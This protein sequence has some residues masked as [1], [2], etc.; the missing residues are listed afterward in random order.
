MK[1]KAISSFFVLF[2]IAAGIVAM[3]PVAFAD[4]SEVTVVPAAGSGSLGC[5]EV[6]YGCYI[7]G[8]A[9]VDL[10]GV[11]IFSNSDSAA[12]T[13][14]AGTA[15]AGPTGEF[16]TSMVM[17]GNSYEWTADV[18]GEIPYFCMVHPWMTGLIVVQEVEA[19]EHTDEHA[20]EVAEVHMEGT[21]TATGMLSDGTTVSI[22]T[23]TPT[24][25][26]AM[27]I[28]I[29]F[30]DAEHVNHDMMVTQGGEEVLNDEAAHHHDGKGVHTTAPLS[31]SDPVDITITFQG[32]GV[33]D[34]KTGPIGEEVVFSNVVPEF[35]TIAMMIL[36]V[37][38]ISIV[39]V[40]AKSRVVPRF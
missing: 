16:D 10:G 29:E 13:F 9:T 11:V 12:H 25:G 14:S 26:E 22:W 1:T 5:D 38:I 17:A 20:D 27:E 24:A 3:T 28:S 33:D 8:I 2:A 32:Y 37:A 31:S 19:E 23:S 39:A 21:A 18:L 6:E 35:G 40:T 4:H 36:A 15:A 34:P 30:E 7:P